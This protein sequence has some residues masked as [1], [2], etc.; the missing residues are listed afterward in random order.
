[1]TSGREDKADVF[2]ERERD[3]EIERQIEGICDRR[4]EREFQGRVS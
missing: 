1:M 3:G 2:R 4:G